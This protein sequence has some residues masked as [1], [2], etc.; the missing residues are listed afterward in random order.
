MYII[1]Y[2]KKLFFPVSITFSEFFTVLY[3]GPLSFI[4]ADCKRSWQLSKTGRGVDD[5]H[6]AVLGTK[7]CS[8]HL[9]LGV[10]GNAV[11]YSGT[12][13]ITKHARERTSVNCGKGRLFRAGYWLIHIAT[14]A[15]ESRLCA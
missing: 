4:C 6:G 2:Y 3:C 8:Q 14:G 7:T 9:I 13:F 11:K 12:S 10:G 15:C 5:W 1:L